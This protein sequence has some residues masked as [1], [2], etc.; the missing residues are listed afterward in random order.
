MNNTGFIVF[1]KDNGN[2]K[3]YYHTLIKNNDYKVLKI[4]YYI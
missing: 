3:L 1:I 2:N 4:K